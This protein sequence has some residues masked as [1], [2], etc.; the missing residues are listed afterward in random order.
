MSCIVNPVCLLVSLSKENHMNQLLRSTL[1]A[2]KNMCVMIGP[3]AELDYCLNNIS[4]FKK[5]QCQAHICN[6]SIK[7]EIQPEMQTRFQTYLFVFYAVLSGWIFFFFFFKHTYKHTGTHAI[8]KQM[9]KA[10]ET[11]KSPFQLVEQTCLPSTRLKN[12]FHKN[13]I[14][15][16]HPGFLWDAFSRVLSGRGRT[17]KGRRGRADKKEGDRSS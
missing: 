14:H 15:L 4:T 2:S 12:D 6:T 3:L 5:R 7:K 17:R 11:K 1:K 9:T 10:T 16:L 13:C 8:E